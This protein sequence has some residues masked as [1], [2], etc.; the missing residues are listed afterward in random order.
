MSTVAPVTP[1]ATHAIPALGRF[2]ERTGHLAW[3]LVRVTTGALL[4]PHGLRNLL[5]MFGGGSTDPQGFFLDMGVQPGLLVSYVI[6]MLQI[7]C[8]LLLIVGFGTRLAALLVALFMAAVALFAHGPAGFF[9]T[10]GG[11]EYPLMWLLLAVAL[12]L[13]GGGDHSLDR[14][15]RVEL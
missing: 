15:L 6:G 8:G 2:Y 4:L 3:P 12:M 11:F 5:G 13:K 10:N 1:R 9:W 7:V 14:K